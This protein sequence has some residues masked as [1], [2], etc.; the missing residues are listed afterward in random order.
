MKT[1]KGENNIKKGK[2]HTDKEKYK[3]TQIMAWKK[4]IE[5]HC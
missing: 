2:Q 3:R 4:N 1:T 5:K